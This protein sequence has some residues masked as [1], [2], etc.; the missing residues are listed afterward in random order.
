MNTES[1]KSA[2]EQLQEIGIV[3]EEGL[4]DAEVEAVQKRFG[5]V[6]PPDLKLFLQTA[7]PISQPP[8]AG[9][10][11]SN[12]FSQWRS[13]EEGELWNRLQAPYQGICFD[14]KNNGFWM[15]DWGTRPASDEDACAIARDQVNQAPTL[16]PIYGH[17]YM[18]DAPR[19]EGNPIYSV[20]QTDIIYYG[21]DLPGYLA[22]EFNISNPYP[23]P[24]KPRRIDFWSYLPDMWLP[25]WN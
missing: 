8:G 10:T 1:F 7:L 2:I 9:S 16:I 3:F 14:I 11:Y 12:P 20:W 15:G 4:S 22:H 19:L 25:E 6:L 5:F 17:R 23:E 24:Q 13:G 18:P 21:L